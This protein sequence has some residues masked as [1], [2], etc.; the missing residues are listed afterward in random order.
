LISGEWIGALAMSEA[1]SGSDVVSMKTTATKDGDHYILNGT[2]YWITNGP[3][4]DVII[5]YAKTD[6]KASKPQHGITA[7]IVETKTAGFS[8]GQKMV[9]LGMRGSHTGE[10]IF[11]NCRIPAS[12]VLGEVNRGVY[13][14][15]S[16]LDIE[17]LVLA[18]GPL[19]LMQASCDLAFNY[20]QERKSFGQPIANYQFVQGLMADMYTRMQSCRSYVYAMAKQLDIMKKTGISGDL[21]K[22]GGFINMDCAGSILISAECATKVAL[23][24]IQILGGAGYTYDYPAGRLLRDAKLY[25]IGAGTTEIRKMVIARVINDYYKRQ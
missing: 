4:A 24:A 25:E 20:A 14:M 13:V 6:P 7:F 17:R 10:L 16:G 12:N 9:K 3:D 15:F 11:E 5:V 18:A 23:D 21:G 8:V 22:K 19:G 1:E 2:K